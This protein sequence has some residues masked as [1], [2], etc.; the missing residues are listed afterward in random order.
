MTF[1]TASS[2]SFPLLRTALVVALALT[3]LS[4][5]AQVR[6]AQPMP[7][8]P[9]PLVP[10]EAADADTVKLLMGLAD[11][12]SDLHIGM[13]FLQQSG[14]NAAAPYLARGSKD[15]WPAVKD[16][17][18]AVG[19]PDIAPALAELEK[20]GDPITVN[21]RHAEVSV[22]I[23]KA[24]TAL[25]PT[26]ADQIAA[27]VAQGQAIAAKLNAAGPTDAE[28]YRDAWSLLLTTRDNLDLLRRDLDP[29]VVAAVGEVA[30]AIDDLILSMPDPTS[31]APATLDPAQ[32]LAAFKPLAD[33]AGT[34]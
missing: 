5:S 14:V 34:V 1:P 18:L 6:P 27:I 15:H 26:T 13:L 12:Q 4:A 24:R 30:R 33:V 17:I 23:A 21:K 16:G 22:G 19:G 32:V 8:A 20:G 2:A 31:S 9:T 29:A 25:A 7:V 10:A 3:S 11:I 28:A